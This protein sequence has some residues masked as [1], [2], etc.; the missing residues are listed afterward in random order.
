MFVKIASLSN[1]I[2]SFK[3]AQ[4]D[5][6]TGS[7]T[8]KRP[9]GE[10]GNPVSAAGEKA[11]LVK[12]GILAGL[13]YGCKL[14]FQLFD[15][16]FAFEQFN[17]TAGKIVSKQKN[18]SPM[19][20]TVKHI[21]VFAGLSMMFIAG[22]A[23]LY[24][25]FKAPEINYEGNIKAFKHKKDMDVYI[26]GNAVEKELYQQMNDKAQGADADEKNKLRGLYMQMSAAKNKVPDFV[27][28]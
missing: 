28:R 13:G 7:K 21:G 1:S 8:D 10:N 14:L 9:A 24:T 25:L 12:A 17:K 20:R 18:L 23:A 26:K 16:D 2:Y 3:S 11:V 22:A 27:N 5:K 15:G 6:N 19:Q 4:P